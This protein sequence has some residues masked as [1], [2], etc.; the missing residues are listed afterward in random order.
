MIKNAAT[1]RPQNRYFDNLVMHIWYKG[2]RGGIC[3]LIISNLH[4]NDQS[5]RGEKREIILNFSTEYNRYRAVDNKMY[6]VPIAYYIKVYR[7]IIFSIMLT[8]Q[9][10]IA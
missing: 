4:E 9:H 8:I 7:I 3:I 5:V 1:P 6:F 10:E 2:S